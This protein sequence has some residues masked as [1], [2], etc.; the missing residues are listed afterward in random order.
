M[1]KIPM[2]FTNPSP[3][4]WTSPTA[5][6]SPRPWRP[7]LRTRPLYLTLPDRR[8]EVNNNFLSS[9]TEFLILFFS[10]G[11]TRSAQVDAGFRGA[12]LFGMSGIFHVC[13]KATS[14]S[15]LWTGFLSKM[16]VAFRTSA[17]FW[18]PVAGSCLQP[19]LHR[20][21]ASKYTNHS[22]KQTNTI[23]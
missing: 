8:K 14:L 12:K 15:S 6:P 17:P 10:S 1:L 5:P 4:C 20:D 11:K 22:N 18:P 2:N 19:V 23:F 9:F 7:I 16:L 13:Q 3:H 21:P